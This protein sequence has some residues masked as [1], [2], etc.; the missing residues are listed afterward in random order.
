MYEISTHL[1][2]VVLNIIYSSLVVSILKEAASAN[3][4]E[5]VAR[6]HT[7]MSSHL[8][9]VVKLPLRL[10][11]QRQLSVV[12][13]DLYIEVPLSCFLDEFGLPEEVEEREKT[14][15]GDLFVVFSGIG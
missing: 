9:Y 15:R 12:C 7:W 5:L 14:R 6:Q 3:T 4:F 1:K 2:F 10:L 8:Q 11:R 13:L